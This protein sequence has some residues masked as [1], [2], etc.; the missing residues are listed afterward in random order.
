MYRT[1]LV[2]TGLLTTLANT[3]G[4]LH[5]QSSIDWFEGP[6]KAQLG[7]ESAFTIPGGC[8]FTEREGAR[9]FMIDTEN[10]PTGSELGVLVCESESYD[11]YWFVVFSYDASGYVHDDEG[12]S[13]DADAILSSI[14]R[15][16]EKSNEY[17]R[18]QGWES[19]RV[20]G[21]STPPYYDPR[22]NNLTWA[23]EAES[24]GADRVVN[25]SVRLLGRGGVMHV[26]LVASP[27][28]VVPAMPMFG[29]VVAS[30]SYVAGRRYAEWREGDKVASYGLTALVAGGV[31][32][33]AVKSGLLGRL[34]KL[35]LIPIVA[36]F[37]WLK[38]LF[39]RKEE[40][41]RF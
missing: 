26:D 6:G 35:I 4:P 28:Q 12:S 40:E 37:A 38:S 17:R 25:H 22:T 30:H 14:R 3:S 9:Q 1:T 8:A 13:I 20:T 31:G 11:D 41:P 18:R 16:T 10:Q 39:G 19:L 23:I 7:S 2:L 21:W 32:A 27:E 5:A 29:S 34:W 24:G 36:L 15:G 33:A